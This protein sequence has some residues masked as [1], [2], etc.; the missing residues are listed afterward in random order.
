MAFQEGLRRLGRKGHREAVI[1]LR[2]IHHQ[3][4]RLALHSGDHHHRF[5]EVCLRISRWM[6]QRYEHL[7]LAQLP[8]PHVVLDD[9]VAA[10]IAVFVTQPLENPLGGVPLLPAFRLVVFQDL[11]DSP[12][13][14][15]QFGPAHGLL[16]P[17]TRW[18]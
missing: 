18:H 2:Q 14:G 10:R 17:V 12:H 4:V 5:P 1:G 8:E 15:V 13:P 16:P 11:V 9:R 6:F 7:A 3:V